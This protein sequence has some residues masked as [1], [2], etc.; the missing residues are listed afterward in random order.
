MLDI[1]QFA[2]AMDLDSPLEVIPK[3]K[4]RNARNVIFRG[5]FPNMRA[6]SV[7]GNRLVPNEFLPSSG[8]NKT[9]GAYYDQVFKRVFFFNFNS[10]G[11][12]G[13][14]IYDTVNVTFQILIQSGLNTDGDPLGFT[15]AGTISSIKILYGDSNLGNILFFLDSLKR[16]TQINIDRFL[17]NPPTN[18]K[19][20]YLEVI[21]APPQ[22]PIQAVYE[23]DANVTANNLINSLWKFAYAFIDAD[24]EKSVIATGSIVPLPTIPFDPNKNVDPS[25][26][27][28]IALYLQTGDQSVKSIRLYGK[29]DKDGSISDWL[30][31]DTIKKA[32]LSIPDNAVYRYLFYNNGNYIAEDIKF[33]TLNFDEVPIEANALELLDGTTLAMAGIKEGYDFFNPTIAVTASNQNTPLYTVNG[34][35]F[36]GAT[37]GLFTS[38]QPQIA[39]YLTG[40]GTNDGLGNPT[41][42]MYPP[43]NFFV[44]AKSN[45]SD[46][47]FTY[48]N[49]IDATISNILT[50]IKN[51]AVTAGWVFVSQGTNDLILYYPTGTVTLDNTRIEGFSFVSFTY[52]GPQYAFLPQSVYQLGALYRDSGGRT[53]GTISNIQATV[54][55]PFYSAGSN[56]PSAIRVDLTGTIPPGWAVCGEIVRTDTLTFNKYE[57]WVSTAAYTGTGQGVATNYAYFD[58]SNMTLY[59]DS[60]KATDPSNKGVV[61]Y[62]FSTGDRV[63]VL[64]RY[65][66]NGSFVALNLD[67]AVLGF[68]T[69]IV[70]NG[71]TKIG[72][73]VQIAF[74]TAD[75]NADFKFDGTSDFQNYKILLY[76]YK[77]QNPEG[78][79][80]FYETGIHFGIGNPGLST[81]YHMGN[82]ADNVFSISDGD[83]FF[84]T[85]TVPIGTSYDI[86]T[87]SYDQAT[88]YSTEWTNP[89]GGAIPI[90]DNGI[91]K[92]VGGLHQNAGLLATQYPSYV[93]NDFIILNESANAFSVRLRG[94]QTIIDKTDPNGQFAK[95]I[96]IAAP[97]NIITIV[98]L[99]GLQTGLQ[100]GVANTYTFDTTVSLP[101]GA[102]LWI[103]NYAVNEMLVGA[104]TLKLDV[105]RNRTI[106][107]FDYSYSDIYN[108]KINADNRP[109][110]IDTEAKQTINPVLLRF[111]EP[112]VPGT[113]ILNINRFYDSNEDIFD[114][115]HGAVIRLVSWQ[116]RLRIAQERKWGEIGVYSKFIKN[117]TGQTE[118]IVNDS[119][120]EPNN[121][122]YFDGDFGIGTQARSLAINGF[123]I[124]FP[125]DIRGCLCRLSLNGIENI[126]EEFKVQTFAGFKLPKY[127]TDYNY[128]FGGKAEILGCYNYRK[129]LDAETLFC[130]QGGTSGSSGV[131]AETLSFVER[132]NTFPSFYD[133]APDSL[134]C[135]ENV[136]ISFYNGEM[137]IHDNDTTYAN[138]FGHQ[139]KPSVELIF[140]DQ[141]AIKKKF[142]ALSLQAYNN[143]IWS[144][145]TLGDITTS[146]YN[147]QTFLQQI[148]QLLPVDFEIQ[149]GNVYAAF[150]RDYLSGINGP[151]ALLEGDYLEGFWIRVLLSAQDAGFN[152]L[153]APFV[154]WMPQQKTP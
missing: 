149:E 10:A 62:G 91:W 85:R 83:V 136:L 37:N 107:I 70:V 150:L 111:S 90:V 73:F 71:V 110:L 121:I 45:G 126:S 20:S 115:S 100:P 74:P 87:G 3:E 12:H 142:M 67:Y 25:Q 93:D 82:I 6:E 61:S 13:I 5:T 33:A 16:P 153:N 2:G 125:D 72:S 86:S 112:E 137:Y 102:K 32:D 35:L 55:T 48:T 101:A 4:H 148:S 96:K 29:Q 63:R 139:F 94:T 108:L 146:F 144:A 49:V 81:A 8:V 143:K 69:T 51:A 120:I 31:L 140:N 40:A 97:G 38:G 36:F 26:N 132:S 9:I 34:A 123:Q 105:I 113:N 151:I 27:A 15:A 135:A 117:N 41:I 128:A 46:I 24:N 103:V 66:V 1:K 50:G 14:I 106:D 58:I 39:F 138:F 88:T 84:R 53:N 98:Q 76:S 124:W 145:S 23:N 119:I 11:S 42:L 54:T 18:I 131:I 122:Q 154:R 19:R 47:G 133:F 22:S 57:D 56:Q 44:R 134:V 129:D 75:I 104:Y 7:V 43:Q 30:I 65:A 17:N 92:I 79:N 60:I 21:K 141:I 28:R 59:N 80:V 77:P 127:L 130:F 99:L 116:R 152:F 95:Y 68:T 114:A 147:P 52:N 78:Q 64:G 89:G 118:L 109:S